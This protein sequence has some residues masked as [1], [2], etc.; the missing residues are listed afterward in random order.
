M[1]YN[2]FESCHQGI[3]ELFSYLFYSESTISV[4]K[5]HS[6]M[7]LIGVPIYLYFM[8]SLLR[9]CPINLSKNMNK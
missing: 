6:L 7:F 2:F 5:P 8:D 1:F 9:L 4:H 3:L